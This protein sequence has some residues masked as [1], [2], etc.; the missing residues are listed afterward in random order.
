MGPGLVAGARPT[1]ET[2]TEV[3]GAGS[4]AAPPRRSETREAATHPVPPPWEPLLDAVG[5]R[6]TMGSSPM[7][8]RREALGAREATDARRR[9]RVVENGVGLADAV[10]PHPRPL[11]L[12]RGDR[13]VAAPLAG[14]PVRVGGRAEVSRLPPDS[15]RTVVS[16]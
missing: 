6:P 8:P 9:G 15:H 3:V 1:P 16:T 10:S 13:Q 14:R 12:R 11:P 5:L 7:A 2:E 4:A